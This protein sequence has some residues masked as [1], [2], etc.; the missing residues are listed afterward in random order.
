[1]EL[2][3]DEISFIA[4]CVRMA[5]LEGYYLLSCYYDIDIEKVGQSCLRKIGLSESLINY[6]LN[7]HPFPHG[8]APEE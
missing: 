4:E 8:P 1:M 6:S 5:N 3:K 7:D 2:T